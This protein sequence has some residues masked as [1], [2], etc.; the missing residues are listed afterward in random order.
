MS[1]LGSRRK[2][3]LYFKNKLRG[4]RAECVH[5]F[6]PNKHKKGAMMR[7]KT[8]SLAGVLVLMLYAR[9]AWA[10]DLVYLQ[11]GDL[12]HPNGA[13][14][15]DDVEAGVGWQLPWQWRD[16]AFSTRLDTALGYTH[17]HGENSWRVMVSPVLRYQ[18][19]P[20]HGWFIEGGV[21]V[22][23]LTNTQ[24]RYDYNLDTHAQFE[25]RIG[26]GYQVGAN[27]I[28]LN[29]THFS[30]GGLKQP[31]PGAEIVSLRY[32]RHF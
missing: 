32:S 26:V 30:N 31:N 29:L 5:D 22:A 13:H 10:A 20:A 14:W 7:R 11:G 18:A 1:R 25:D 16:G 17:S 3:I 2:L 8:A 27:E 19:K 21:G 23:Y 6:W 4:G 28:S 12:I 15:I 9:G 24:W